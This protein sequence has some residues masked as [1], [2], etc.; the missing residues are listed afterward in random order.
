MKADTNRAATAAISN[1]LTKREYNR[2]RRA[3]A[4]FNDRKEKLELLEEAYPAA[5][6][7]INEYSTAY[8][9]E[10]GTA[11]GKRALNNALLICNDLSCIG[12]SDYKPYAAEAIRAVTVK[13]DEPGDAVPAD[14]VQGL[15]F[16]R[17]NLPATYA[18]LVKL[19]AALGPV[20]P[21]TGKYS[22]PALLMRSALARVAA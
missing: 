9:H 13:G 11:K 12:G 3:Y 8:Y 14:V 21:D 22:A 16:L 5:L 10:I 15:Q 7:A 17:H 2:L 1:P 18:K 20:L 19:D 4:E 6:L